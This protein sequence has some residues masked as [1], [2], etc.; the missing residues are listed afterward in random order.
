MVQQRAL[1]ACEVPG[2]RRTCCG[3][4]A[5]RKRIC[6][7]ST[8]RAAP[9]VRWVR[10]ASTRLKYFR[11]CPSAT[12]SSVSRK[13]GVGPAGEAVQEA[14][15]GHAVACEQLSVVTGVSGRVSFR[16]RPKIGELPA[17]HG[18]MSMRTLLVKSPYANLLREIIDFAAK[19]V[20]GLQ[21][22]GLLTST[23]ERNAGYF[24]R[25]EIISCQLGQARLPEPTALP[26]IQPQAS[27][28][29]ATPP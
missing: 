6:L 27:S 17:N 15:P 23:Q 16:T 8:P 3:A 19:Q 5:P 1:N 13:R 9:R 29:Q 24:R 10:P 7:S 20:M 18:A 14:R 25:P 28:P 4:V 11:L 21:L 26:L 2:P 12:L 22:V